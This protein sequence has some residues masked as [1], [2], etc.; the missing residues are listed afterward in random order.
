M[1]KVRKV[2]ATLGTMAIAG[3]A[4]TVVFCSSPHVAQAD[5]PLPD[6]CSKDRGTIH[7]TT[8]ETDAPHNNWSQTETT[9]KKGS[10]NSSH[11]EV[12]TGTA[13]NPGGHEPPGQQP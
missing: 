2:A 13:T 5:P 1:R 3:G 12:T 11:D 6:G 9:S 8:S 7:C 4:A 10:F